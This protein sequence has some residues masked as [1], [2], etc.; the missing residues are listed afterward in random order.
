MTQFT[1]KINWLGPFSEIEIDSLNGG[2]GLY[3]FTGKRR[4][5][6]S[7]SEIQYI[8]I[9]ENAYRDRLRNHHKI[10]EINRELGIWLGE[11]DYPAEHERKHLE[12]AESIMVYFWQPELNDRKKFTPPVPTTVI[13]HWYSADGKPR[14][15]QKN[16]Y[17]DLPDVICW[18]GSYWRT[19]NLS[20]YEG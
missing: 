4:Y 10:S 14:K 1:I 3:L 13:S 6:R 8:G 15:N 19:G 18:D 11:I 16:I 20:V 5:Q 2:N 17:K 12:T 9:T 7:D